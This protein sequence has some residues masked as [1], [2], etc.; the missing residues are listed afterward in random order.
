MYADFDYDVGILKKYTDD[1]YKLTYMR[2]CRKEGIAV[3]LNKERCT[4][5]DAPKSAA[6]ISRTRAKIKELAIC[7][8][9][10]HFVTLTIDK[11]K[12]D[13][14]DL[15]RYKKKL[16]KWINNYNERQGTAIRYL[17]IPEEHK[18]GA[19]HIHGLLAGIPQEHLQEFTLDCN[20]T[21]RM[22]R[23][24]RR[25]KRLLNW[26]SYAGNFGFVSMELIRNSERAATY[27]AKYVE[28]QALKNRIGRYDNMYYCSQGLKRCEVVYKDNLYFDFV[29]DYKSKDGAV[30]VRYFTNID[31]P[32][33]LFN[34]VFDIPVSSEWFSEIVDDD[35]GD[36]PFLECA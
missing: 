34:G 17:L 2:A 35:V 33:K 12:H 31:E 11:T 26:P 20:I 23:M 1:C 25:G 5:P 8:D 24:I 7:N 9:W 18:D 3:E 29:S 13:R 21:A 30:K 19:W 16:S 15:D 14:Y 27:I 6:S 4:D 22:R 32:M 28:K 36:N 10:E